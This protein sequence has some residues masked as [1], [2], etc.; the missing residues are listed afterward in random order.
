MGWFWQEEG[1]QSQGGGGATGA[2]DNSQPQIG[3]D[4]EEIIKLNKS[5]AKTKA[6]LEQSKRQ[7]VILQKYRSDELY[8]VQKKYQVHID[9]WVAVKLAMVENRSTLLLLSSPDYSAIIKQVFSEYQ[10]DNPNDTPDD[11]DRTQHLSWFCREE[12]KLCRAMHYETIVSQNLLSLLTNQYHTLK[13]GLKNS[14][15]QLQEEHGIMQSIHLS[16]ITNCEKVF[17]HHFCGIHFGS[18]HL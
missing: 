1:Q 8:A 15:L 4:D 7:G 18:S 6:E 13:K 9:H 2:D 12:I 3:H 14:L 5:I 17:H 11:Y 16:T 10:K